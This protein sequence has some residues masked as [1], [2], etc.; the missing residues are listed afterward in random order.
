[1]RAIHPSRFDQAPRNAPCE[2]RS[3]SVD[4]PSAP[5]LRPTSQGQGDRGVVHD[6]RGERPARHAS[7][8]PA[9]PPVARGRMGRSRGDAGRRQGVGG[10]RQT[11]RSERTSA[12]G[13]WSRRRRG[14]PRDASAEDDRDNRR[15]RPASHGGEYCDSRPGAGARE[16]RSEPEFRFPELANLAGLLAGG[17]SRSSL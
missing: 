16:Q 3:G 9:N 1:M 14:P 11:P 15:F 13:A 12:S 2:G 7:R 17:T 10:D 6:C 4:P 8:V 5:G